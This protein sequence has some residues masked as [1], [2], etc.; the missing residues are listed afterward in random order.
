MTTAL[1]PL[2]TEQRTWLG[3]Q[4]RAQLGA[5]ERQVH[6]HQAGQSRV[7]YAA[8]LL[9]QEEG[10]RPQH[11]ADREVALERADRE[12]MTLGAISQ[13]LARIDDPAFGLCEDCDEP[14]AWGRLRLEPWA[15]RCV[16]CESAREGH[17]VHHK[18]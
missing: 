14:I 17:A 8:E 1:A 11:D 6:D 2:S 4:L 3:A 5:L 16:A 13:A 15:L 10:A 9:S 7:D 18:L 12:Q